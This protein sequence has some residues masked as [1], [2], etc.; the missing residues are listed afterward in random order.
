MAEA[1]GL[2]LGGLCKRLLYICILLFYNVVY[3]LYII[4]IFCILPGSEV[5]IISQPL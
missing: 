4:C 5:Q 2:L 3:N 1:L